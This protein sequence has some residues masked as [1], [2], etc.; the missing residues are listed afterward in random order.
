M[1]YVGYANMQQSSPHKTRSNY[2]NERKWERARAGSAHAPHTGELPVRSLKQRS[3]G[4]LFCVSSCT[5]LVSYSSAVRGLITICN[6]CCS[7][8]FY[9]TSLPHHLSSVPHLNCSTSD[10]TW[11]VPSDEPSLPHASV[12]PSIPPC[13]DRWRVC[14]SLEAQK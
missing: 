9:R 7:F 10:G 3:T 4:S 1:T 5:S 14:Q 13:K 2:D 12:S 6:D 8:L 11:T